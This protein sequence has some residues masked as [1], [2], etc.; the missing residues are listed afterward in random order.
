MS[1]R[2]FLIAN[3]SIESLDIEITEGFNQRSPKTPQLHLDFTNGKII[4]NIHIYV[5]M[6]VVVK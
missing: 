2:G 3:D 5:Y 6:Y 4:E 1:A